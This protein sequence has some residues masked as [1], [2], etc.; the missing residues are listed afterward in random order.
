MS[1]LIYM[2][3]GGS[4]CAG[5]TATGRLWS[6]G[7]I[8]ANCDRF[9]GS[10]S[11][12]PLTEQSVS[13]C[14]GFGRMKLWRI[15]HFLIALRISWKCHIIINVLYCAIHYMTTIVV[16]PGIQFVRQSPTDLQWEIYHASLYP[17][18]A[19]DDIINQADSD[20]ALSCMNI[21]LRR[22]SSVSS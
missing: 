22:C 18:E 20:R 14:F 12:Y 4:L 8:T 10:A 1:V 11:R 6:K 3:G 2:R 9:D 19:N 7:Q 16:Q 13:V 21:S 5:I 17:I 15:D